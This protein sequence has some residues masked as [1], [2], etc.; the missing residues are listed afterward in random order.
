[1]QS[2]K[3][4]LCFLMPSLILLGCLSGQESGSTSSQSPPAA[5]S[6]WFCQPSDSLAQVEW[7]NTELGQQKALLLHPG[8]KSGPT[9]LIVFL[10]GDS[11]FRDPIYQYGIAKQISQK[12]K[13]LTMA[14]LRPGYQ[15]DCGD[16]SG[17]EKGLTMGD[18]YT[19]EV[20]T[21]LG[22]AIRLVQLKNRPSKTIIIGHSGG[23]ALTALLASHFPTLA[24]ES[25]LIA[26]PC[27][28]PAWRKSMQA[29]TDNPQWAQALGGLSPLE[30]LEKVALRRKIHMYVGQEDVVTPP[31][32]SQE[33]Y[34]AVQKKGAPVDIHLLDGEDHESILRP[35]IVGLILKN[36]QL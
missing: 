33:F 18:N 34:E 36:A 11:P 31:F 32:L 12:T 14:L 23:A 2:L 3:H 29:L 19:K 4:L 9:K 21:S 8:Q 17:G 26:C 22:A 16:V 25:I 20:V 24:D 30:E 5:D 35:E 27:N 15:D 10:H 7:I 28:L 6:L 1:M 13:A